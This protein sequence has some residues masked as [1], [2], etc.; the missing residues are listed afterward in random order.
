L[1]PITLNAVT[2]AAKLNGEV[3][4]LVVGSGCAKVAEDS[5]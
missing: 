4:G 3:T 5:I 1:N 2:A